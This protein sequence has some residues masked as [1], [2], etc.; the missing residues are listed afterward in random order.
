M[1]SGDGVVVEITEVFHGC[2][3]S[4]LLVLR[5]KE[6]KCRWINAPQN[7]GPTMKAILEVP[8]FAS[9]H[10]DKLVWDDD[11]NGCYSVK[12]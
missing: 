7:E 3:W 1:P 12:F 6:N 10:E 5:Q 2:L 4:D 8:L 9:G 11:K